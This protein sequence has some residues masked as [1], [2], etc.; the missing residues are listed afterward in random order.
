MISDYLSENN[1]RRMIM[2]QGEI[3][4]NR[5]M[6]TMLAIHF[7]DIVSRHQPKGISSH[8]HLCY[9][10]L[11]RIVI[12]TN[13]HQRTGRWSGWTRSWLLQRRFLMENL[14]WSMMYGRLAQPCQPVPPCL[15][16]PGPVQS[17]YLCRTCRSSTRRRC[18]R[19]SGRRLYLLHAL[20]SVHN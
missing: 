17:G 4:N 8:L 15:I 18:V 14:S 9:V 10:F 5:G 12:R 2:M 19:R 13:D 1:D 3:G 16:A 20:K 11:D 7:T 6:G